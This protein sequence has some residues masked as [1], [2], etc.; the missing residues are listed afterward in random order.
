MFFLVS[1][2]GNL[3]IRKI[4]RFLQSAFLGCHFT[5]CFNMFHQKSMISY[6]VFDTSGHFVRVFGGHFAKSTCFFIGGTPR[7]RHLGKRVVKNIENIDFCVRNHTFRTMFLTEVVIS[8]VFL[9][10]ILQNV[11]VSSSGE[12]RGN[13][14]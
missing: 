3:K 4:R 6:D 9:D 14:V 2:P 1:N 11:R 12:P 13:S 10:V 5:T 7:D 8:Y